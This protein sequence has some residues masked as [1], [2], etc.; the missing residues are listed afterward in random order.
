MLISGSIA[1]GGAIVGEAAVAIPVGLAPAEA[2]LQSTVTGG[3]F[4]SFAEI[5]RAGFESLIR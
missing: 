4:A 2:A 1:A 5:L 3:T